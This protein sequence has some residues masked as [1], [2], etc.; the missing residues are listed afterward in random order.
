MTAVAL[1]VAIAL[2]GVMTIADVARRAISM[3]EVIGTLIG[4]V[5]HP[6]TTRLLPELATL[7]TRT[8]RVVLPRAVVMRSRT[9]QMAMLVRMRLDVRHRPV[10]RARLGARHAPAMR[11]HIHLVDATGKFYSALCAL[12]RFDRY[13][14]S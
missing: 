9:Q 7:M 1:H 11:S 14:Y 12:G 3:T 2:V 5:A 6:T 8:M 4:A 13:S 10:V